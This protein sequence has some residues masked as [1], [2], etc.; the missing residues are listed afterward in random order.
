VFEPYAKA[1]SD[2]TGR[3][4]AEGGILT[5]TGMGPCQY[6]QSIAISTP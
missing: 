5:D 4:I 1:V 2:E 6:E 3:W